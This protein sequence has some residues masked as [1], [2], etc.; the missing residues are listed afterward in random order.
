MRDH[1]TPRHV[2]IIMDGNGRWA[3]QKGLSRSQGHLAGVQRVS[4]IVD[5]AI[6]SGVEVLTLYVFSREN[7]KRPAGEVE[8]LMKIIAAAL[9]RKLS[10]LMERRV[11]LRL[12]GRRDGI[13]NDLFEALQRTIQATSG[14][15]RL[16][17]NLAFNYGARTEI[18]DAV[19][20]IVTEVMEGDLQREDVDAD[21]ISSHMYTAGLPDPDLLIRTSGEK[22]IS[23]FLLWQ[24]S[25]A[26]L[27]FSPV[28]WPE[29]DGEEFQKA[30]DDYAARERRFG[31]V[32]AGSETQGDKG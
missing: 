29:F 9:E 25:Y 28:Y 20:E 16:I 10:E 18:V 12:T 13:P 14:N 19:K 21:V 8:A 26:E 17:L 2:A 30:L 11:A 5:A 27:Y 22:R 3:K 6:K 23:N 7:W 32:S 1:N 31:A 4:D 24:L 15:D